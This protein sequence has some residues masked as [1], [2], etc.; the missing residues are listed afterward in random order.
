MDIP[1]YFIYSKKAEIV[2]SS[3][4]TINFITIHQILNIVVAS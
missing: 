3:L 2:L 1:L 4:N